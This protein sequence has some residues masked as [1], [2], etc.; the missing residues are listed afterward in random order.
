MRAVA[1]WF[2][3]LITTSLVVAISYQWLD[4][5]IALFLHRPRLRSPD[6]WWALLTNIPNPL[7][8]VAVVA[9]LALGLRALVERPLPGYQVVVIVC[10]IS[11][12]VTELIKDKLK[13]LFGRSWPE[14]WMGN[15]P[16][17]IRDGVY[18]FHFMQGGSVFSAFPSG[19]MA[20][21]CAALA[22]LW[23]GYPRFRLLYL[24][25]GFGVGA[26]LVGANYHF[27]SDVIAGAFLGTS[28]G[29][30]VSSIWQASGAPKMTP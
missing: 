18:E 26:G 30:L 23:L 27:L 7:I 24:L 29:W 16:S 21:S 12:I 10:S 11:V 8:P 20:T 3:A 28:V 1:G 4:R 6:S 14:S 2:S 13:F 5:P 25:A 22:V 19:H 17:F 9:L 15:N